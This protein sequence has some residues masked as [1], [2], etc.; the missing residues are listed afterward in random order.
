MIDDTQ[1][2]L[3][4]FRNKNNIAFNAYL[5]KLANVDVNDSVI[6]DLSEDM[7]Q[8]KFTFSKENAK[9]KRDH[10]LLISDGG[11]NAKSDKGGLVCTASGLAKY[12]KI[13]PFFKDG[14][15]QK[16][17]EASNNGGAKEWVI[18]LAPSYEQKLTDLEKLDIKSNAKG[19]YRYVYKGNIVYI[20][21]GNLRE[22]FNDKQRKEWLF[23][24]IEYSEYNLDDDALYALEA[25]AIQTFV[26]D[27]EGK[28][29][30][31][32][33]LSGHKKL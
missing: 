9:G 24:L 4:T 17:Y 29:P 22:R 1:A 14:K 30:H 2:P 26:E 13:R 6:I 20:G 12:P 28:L 18:K 25:E 19:I 33:K 21:N 8:M 5:R 27:N 23:D 3:V 31:Y 11:G 32:N 15:I 10:H 7:T 16:K